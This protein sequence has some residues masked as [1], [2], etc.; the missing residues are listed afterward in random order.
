MKIAYEYESIDLIRFLTSSSVLEV[1]HNSENGLENG[2]A[3]VPP[4]FQQQI[5]N[6]LKNC[7]K[8]SI[9]NAWR[10]EQNENISYDPEITLYTLRLIEKEIFKEFL[11]EKVKTRLMIKA[12]TCPYIPAKVIEFMYNH[13]YR[14]RHK[15]IMIDNHRP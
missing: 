5:F 4:N 14:I 3:N 9:V 10:Q 13:G 11:T 6:E 8:I 2:P 7:L 12:S 15:D 1:E